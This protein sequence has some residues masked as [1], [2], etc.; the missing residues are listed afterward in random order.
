MK[1]I[2]QPLIFAL[3][4]LSRIPVGKTLQPDEAL[5]RKALIT[6]PI[7]GWL[8]GSILYAAWLLAGLT[9]G[10]N[11]LTAAV[12]IVVVET[13]LTGAFHLDGLADTCDAFFSSGKSREEM[14][15]I[16]KDSR[17]GVMGCVALV[18]ALLLK[19]ALI[20]GLCEHHGASALLCYPIAGRWA[21][22]VGYVFSPYV[23]EGGIGSIF[24]R[25]ADT[26]TLV[27]GSL[28]LVPC[29]ALPGFTT[30]FL[31]LV[32]FLFLYRGYV[33]RRIGGITGDILGS[34][35]VLS[36]IV[37]LAGIALVSK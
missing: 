9:P 32:V 30:A 5:A 25:N 12:I 27:A 34:M 28:F 2:I 20:A 10:L 37:V 4:F 6:F 22:V 14:L 23:R 24:S 3:Q 8:I 1:K 35:T 15:A 26:K 31:L 16:M 19:T 7:V 11:I 13:V 33:H 18:L 36:E 29:F 21:Q 17:I